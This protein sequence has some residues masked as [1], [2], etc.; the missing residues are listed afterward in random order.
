[1]FLHL[2]CLQ[3]CIFYNIV[4][5]F[6]YRACFCVIVLV[7]FDKLSFMCSMYAFTVSTLSSL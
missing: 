3:F 1:M 4:S 5:K 2:R 7:I 6:Y